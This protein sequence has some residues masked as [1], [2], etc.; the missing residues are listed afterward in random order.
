M[1]VAKGCK[2]YRKIHPVSY[3]AEGIFSQVGK[4]KK[5]MVYVILAGTLLTFFIS[6]YALKT[7]AE[8]IK[9]VSDAS[10]NIAQDK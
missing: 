2:F 5:E 6:Y 8:S 7:L 4:V 3:F 1:S 9:N 10:N